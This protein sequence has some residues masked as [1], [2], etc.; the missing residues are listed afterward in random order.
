MKGSRE[1]RTKNQS[2]VERKEDEKIGWKE[3]GRKTMIL[4]FCKEGKRNGEWVRD[5]DG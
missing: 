4:D 5:E 1:K 3:V 2:F